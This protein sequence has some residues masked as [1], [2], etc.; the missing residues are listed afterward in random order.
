MN[1]QINERKHDVTVFLFSKSIVNV[2][3]RKEFH[4]QNISVA[5][6]GLNKLKYCLKN[7][8]RNAQFCCF[9]RNRIR[10]SPDA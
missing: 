9:P 8:A 7:V 4:G 2:F 10:F 6:N 5:F 1:V 3:L